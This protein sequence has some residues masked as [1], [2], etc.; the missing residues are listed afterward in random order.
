MDTPRLRVWTMLSHSWSWDCDSASITGCR[1][2]SGRTRC[3]PA[4]PLTSRAP[5]VGRHEPGYQDVIVPADARATTFRRARGGGRRLEREPSSGREERWPPRTVDR[6]GDLP[7]AVRRTQW[8]DATGR[9]NPCGTSRL[10]GRYRAWSTGE[11]S[12]SAAQRWAEI[13]NGSSDAISQ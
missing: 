12:A 4:T 1:H 8:I 9:T 13:C 5:R 3:W 6:T 7:K 11:S 10:A 2:I